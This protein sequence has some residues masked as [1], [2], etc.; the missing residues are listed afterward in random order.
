MSRNIDPVLRSNGLHSPRASMTRAFVVLVLAWVFVSFGLGGAARQAAAEDE[1]TENA[2][3]EIV[4]DFIA[5]WDDPDEAVGFLAENASVR[6][7]EDQPP[8]VGRKAIAEV[9]KSF[10]K[11]GVTL[12]VETFETTSRGPVVVNRRVDTMTT[13]EKGAEIFPVIGVFVVKSGKIIEWTD[14]L[15]K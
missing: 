5:A 10:M 7:I 4:N 1:T 3:V 2:N 15:D 14:Y 11:P 13:P 12:T 9:F 8:V 6:M